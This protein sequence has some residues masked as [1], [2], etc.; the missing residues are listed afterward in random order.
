MKKNREK[1]RFFLVI[2]EKI[3]NKVL[4]GTGLTQWLLNS[5][6]TKALFLFLSATRVPSLFTNHNNLIFAAC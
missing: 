6:K 1:E 3:F 4:F 2:G 5:A